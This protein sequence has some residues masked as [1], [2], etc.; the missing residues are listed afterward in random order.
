MIEFRRIIHIDTGVCSVKRFIIINLRYP[1]PHSDF[2]L[3]SFFS[4]KFAAHCG[5]SL[6]C[7]RRKGQI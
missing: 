2:H 5:A 4:C 3:I 1:E 6:V 7:L